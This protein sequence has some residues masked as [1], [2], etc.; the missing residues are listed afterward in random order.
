RDVRGERADRALREV[1]EPRA[2]VDEH[3]ALREQRVRRS[4]AESDDQELHERLQRHR[5]SRRIVE[6][7]TGAAT[8]VRSLAVQ[9]VLFGAP[10]MLPQ[11]TVS[12][13]SL[14]FSTKLPLPTGDFAFGSHS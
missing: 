13:L 3:R 11:S 5:P 10:K 2:A 9:H 12:K 14:A 1:D 8:P 4:G 7:R 6:D